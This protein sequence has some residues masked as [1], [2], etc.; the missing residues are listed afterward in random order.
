MRP[1]SFAALGATALLV[2]TGC[3]PA[4][5]NAAPTPS[6]EPTVA[7]SPTPTIDPGPVE[8]DEKAASER[9]LGIVCQRNAINVQLHD[10]FVAQEDTFFNGG[11]PDV[12]AAKAAAAEGLRVNRLAIELIDDTYYTWPDGVGP[13]LQAIRTAYLGLAS[14][15]DLIVN[16]TRFEDAYYAERAN[17]EA[18]AAAAQELRYQLGLPADTTSSCVGHEQAADTLHAEMTERNEYLATFSADAE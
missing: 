9:Y 18:A 15:Y 10:A 12:S 7:P 13:H 14:Y 1:S 5:T 17:D 6:A 2:L 11:N 8:L 16:S 4:T 3:A